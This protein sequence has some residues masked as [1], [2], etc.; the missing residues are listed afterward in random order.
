MGGLSDRDAGEGSGMSQEELVIL[1]K[2]AKALL[3][4]YAPMS[5]YGDL[6]DDVERLGYRID[7]AT[8]SPFPALCLNCR[9]LSAG[10][11]YCVECGA[12]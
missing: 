12:T 11:Y 8:G 6:P 9:K 3:F 7:Q 5:R 4:R 1:L 10:P 2:E